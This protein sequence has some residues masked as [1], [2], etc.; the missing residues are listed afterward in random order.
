MSELAILNGI[1]DGVDDNGKTERTNLTGLRTARVFVKFRTGY[2]IHETFKMITLPLRVQVC[3]RRRLGPS[4]TRQH[5]TTS[6]AQQ[7]GICHLVD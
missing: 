7:T 4:L 1:I 2:S 5:L 3:A 6:S